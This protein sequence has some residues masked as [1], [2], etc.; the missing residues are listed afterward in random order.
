[1]NDVLHIIHTDI[2]EYEREKV[3]TANRKQNLLNQ[4]ADE[5]IKFSIE[6]GVRGDNTPFKNISRA[7]KK[8]VQKAKDNNYP[9]VIVS[10]DDLQFVAPGAWNYYLENMPADFSLYMGVI[11]NGNVEDQRVIDGFSGGLTLYTVHNNFYDFFL[12]IS[13]EDHIDRAL[14]K[15]CDK[16]LYLTP[17]KFVV[18]QMG[19]YS[20]NQL[21][22][23]EYGVYEEGREFF[24]GL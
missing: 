7:H 15:F 11:Y 12:N 5:R 4:C 20:F 16:Y 1:M 22:C 13:E 18:K 21:M 24:T 9:Y 23:L 17:P 10:E 19:G 14:G 2:T 6:S 8:V 3:A